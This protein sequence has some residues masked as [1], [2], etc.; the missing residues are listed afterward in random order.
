VE[1]RGDEEGESGEAVRKQWVFVRWFGCSEWEFMS[2]RIG[3]SIVEVE[4]FVGILENQMF[5]CGIT[6]PS[7]YHKAAVF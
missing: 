5:A 1:G 2:S 7:S 4:E 6:G 3:R